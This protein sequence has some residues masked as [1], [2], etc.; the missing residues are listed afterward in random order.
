MPQK[1]QHARRYAKLP[2]LLRA[3]RESAGFTQRELA[4][5][6]RWPQPTVHYSES[7]S[8]RVDV[9]EFCDW[10]EVCGVDPHEALDLFRGKSAATSGSAARKP[11]R[12]SGSTR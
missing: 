2:G 10:C 4:A 11:R 5:K 12:A 3:L 7:G 9:A 6:L 1:P 8:R